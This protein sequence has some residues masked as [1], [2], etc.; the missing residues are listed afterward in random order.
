MIAS[1]CST[2]IEFMI[3]ICRLFYLPR[4]F[5]TLII[6]AVYIPPSA[7]T[8]EALCI[9]YNSISNLHT[10]HPEGVFIVAAD[11]NQANMETFLPN[12]YQCVDFDTRGENTLDLVYSNIKNTFRADPRPYLGSSDHLS[13]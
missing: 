3:I 1:H 9:L 5:S 7:N 6:T 11:F 13:C 8:K 12:F 10:K 4:E 2:D